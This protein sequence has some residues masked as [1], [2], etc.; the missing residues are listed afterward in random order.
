MK[1]KVLAATLLVFSASLNADFGDSGFLGN[2]RKEPDP[3]TRYPYEDYM[4][5]QES[6]D[7]DHPREMTCEDMGNC[8]S[9][10]FDDRYRNRYA[11]RFKPWLCDQPYYYDTHPRCSVYARPHRN[12]NRPYRN[13][14]A[15]TGGQDIY[16]G[17]TFQVHL[18]SIAAFEETRNHEFL[19]ITR[20][21]ARIRIHSWMEAQKVMEEYDEIQQY[22][23]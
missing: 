20:G 6:Q 3:G 19:L 11:P 22:C 21:G 5:W 16:E 8:R 18:C 4:Q 15:I 10:W 2:D 1:I 14:E 9:D 7:V 17:S 12:I 13:P 23:R